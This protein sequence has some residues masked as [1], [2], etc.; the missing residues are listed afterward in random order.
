MGANSNTTWQFNA[1]GQVVVSG[2]IYSGLEVIQGGSATDTLAGPN[3]AA[4]WTIEGTGSGQISV[5]LNALRFEA[6]ENLTGGSASD[7]FEILSTG[8]VTGN[9]NGGT[10]GGINSLNYASWTSG[11]SVTLSAATAGNASAVA[12]IANNL[13]IVTGGSGD[14]ILTGNNSRNSTL[15][16]GEGNDTLA[17]LSGRD[18]LIGGLGA[19]AI[20]GVGGED[21]LI[22]G[23]T[24][25]D[26]DRDAILSIIAEWTNTQRN[27]N[28]RVSNLNGTGTGTRLNGSIFLNVDSVF[29]DAESLDSLTGGAGSDW[30]FADAIEI[31]DFVSADRRN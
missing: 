26:E 16:G 15:I 3:L 1:T 22:S 21:L 13:T 25:H 24:L 18:I 14:D 5:G 19:D 20:S 10:G 23:R 7:D 6:I 27:F 8:Q 2:I 12:G 28:T 30:F 9:L 29:N 31:T 4:Y 17:G 11:L